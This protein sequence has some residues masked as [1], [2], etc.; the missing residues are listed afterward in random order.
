MVCGKRQKL[1]QE[2]FGQARDHAPHPCFP[3]PARL[4]EVMARLSRKEQSSA[5]HG[6]RGG[7]CNPG[8]MMVLLYSDVTVSRLTAKKRVQRNRRGLLLHLTPVSA[9]YV[10]YRFCPNKFMH[11]FSRSS[12]VVA[13]S[14]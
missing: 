11:S 8:S 10:R 14:K 5:R 1:W 7:S 13:R 3:R 2:N 4:S 12:V 9:A 6:H